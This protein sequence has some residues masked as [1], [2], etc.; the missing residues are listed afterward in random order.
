MQPLSETTA[1][2]DLRGITRVTVA[3]IVCLS[4]PDQ[5][6]KGRPI[7]MPTHE[8]KISRSHSGDVLFGFDDNEIS[9]VHAKFSPSTV[10]EWQIIDEGSRNG[11]F[12]N[13]SRITS[14]HLKTGDVIRVGSTLLLYQELILDVGEQLLS[15]VAPALIGSSVALKRV[16]DSA[17]QIAQK[18]SSVLIHGETGVGKE[19]VANEIHRI[20][21]KKGPFIAVNCGALAPELAASE[22][23]GHSAGSFTGASTRTE[24]LFHAADG[25]TL[26]L[27]EIGELP[28][29]IQPILLRALETGSVRSI[30]QNR[31]KP[32]NTRIVA[33]TNKNLEH[34][35]ANGTFR[36]DLFARI[37]G[38][39]ICVPP[40]RKRR[41]DILDI[42]RSFVEKAGMFASFH[43][44]V[45][46][47]LTT[48]D[49]SLI[50]I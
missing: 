32:F 16:I 29:K 28:A 22:L 4:S 37:N 21:N 24:G 50:H 46:E 7:I 38:W 20:S 45:E 41:E 17:H 42:A 43:P 49:L 9:R 19:L 33:A 13:G 14:H 1:Q 2:A 3:R 39:Q 27:D 15:G 30:G 36:A 44:D 12:V 10:T 5:S 6:R 18:N 25:G 31:S 8:A 35:V 11:S 23:F 34:E 47:S 26:F 40:L 48:H